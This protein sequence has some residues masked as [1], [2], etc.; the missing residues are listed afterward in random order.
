MTFYAVII[1]D[2]YGY[3]YRETIGLFE[4]KE[5][6]DMVGKAYVSSEDDDCDYVVKEM[7]VCNTKQILEKLKEEEKDFLAEKREEL[8]KYI[9]QT[10]TTIDELIKIRELF[11][12]FNI[13]ENLTEEKF[14]DVLPDLWDLIKAKQLNVSLCYD[15]VKYYNDGSTFDEKKPHRELMWGYRRDPIIVYIDESDRGFCY[16]YGK[17]DIDDD[18]SEVQKELQELQTQLDEMEVQ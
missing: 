4:T 5:A 6:A 16:N 1:F 14:R 17:Y 7:E 10:K 13:P 15:K 9:E 8:E 18:I 3:D 12:P 2:N 11:K